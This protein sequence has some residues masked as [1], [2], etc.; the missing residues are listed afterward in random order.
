M[1]SVIQNSFFYMSLAV[2]RVSLA[3]GLGLNY[4]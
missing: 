3:E 4:E 1:S 2:D